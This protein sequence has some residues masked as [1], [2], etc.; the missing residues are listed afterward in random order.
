MR[1]AILLLAQFI[2]LSFSNKFKAMR[3]WAFLFI[4]HSAGCKMNIKP[5]DWQ[6]NEKKVGDR[7]KSKAFHPRKSSMHIG[8][9]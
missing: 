2:F 8:L 3:T 7:K 6:K 4:C 9:V 1:I 5:M